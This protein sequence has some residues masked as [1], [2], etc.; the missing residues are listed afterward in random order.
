MTLTG[1]F[2]V[3][4]LEILWYHFC[5]PLKQVGLRFGSCMVVLVIWKLSKRKSVKIAC[6]TAEDCHNALGGGVVVL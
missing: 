3:V 2:L 6:E 5:D 4:R 1:I